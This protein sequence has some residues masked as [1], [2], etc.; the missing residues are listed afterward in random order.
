MYSLIGC[1]GLFADFMNLMKENVSQHQVSHLI[2]QYEQ[3]CSDNILLLKEL[4]KR[5]VPGQRKFVV[6][7]IFVN[8]VRRNKPYLQ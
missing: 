4:V 3:L 1:T 6:Q 8:I 7:L 2:S 5:A